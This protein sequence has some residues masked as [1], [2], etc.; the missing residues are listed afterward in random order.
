MEVNNIIRAFDEYLFSKK[1]SFD[2]IVIGGAALSIMGVIDRETRDIDCLDPKIPL[3][4]LQAS[5]NF[6]S[7]NPH[8]NLAAKWLNNGP[9]SLVRELPSRWRLRIVPIFNGKAI[10]LSTLGRSDLLKTKLFAL[11]DRD[12]DFQDCIKMNPS[13]E[14][15]DKCFEWV[16][17]RDANPDWRKNVENHF[18]ELKKELGHGI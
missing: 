18:A 12:F 13:Q 3:E 15:L 9:D 8:L 1:L 5:E 14:E 10:H 6:R 7:E 17:E 16:S 11:C 4:I 2:S